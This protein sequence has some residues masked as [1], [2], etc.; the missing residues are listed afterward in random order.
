MS[1]QQIEMASRAGARSGVRALVAG[2]IGSAALA[3]LSLNA[4]APAID[5]V[6]DDV[7][8]FF[9]VYEAAAGR[10]TA[11]QIQRDYLDRG[12]A[13]LRHLARVRNLTGE[14]IAQANAAEPALYINARACLPVLPRVR[15]R[16]ARTFERLLAMYPAAQRPPVTILVS[17]GRPLALAGPGNGV[18]VALEG[19]CSTA[20]ARVLDPDVDERFVHVIA[21]EYI[22]AQQAPA[23]ADT[24]DLTVLQ[25]SLLEGIAE[26][27]GE[28][29][30]GGI[31]HAGIAPSAKGR[32]RDIETRFAASI[33]SKDLSAWVDN[34]TADEVGQLGYWVGYRIA[35]AHYRRASDKRAAFRAMIEMTD[36]RAFLAASGWSPGIDLN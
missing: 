20:A 10:P 23:L 14:R 19:M 4:Q 34:T 29:I 26:F 2:A 24:E 17:R 28:L 3:C 6:T 7:E 32:E 16:L 25:R 35:K 9:S 13:G 31:A 5:I 33:D 1:G 30:S 15:A 8:R 36:A 22:H 18:Q 27:A 21:H 11:Q 12:T